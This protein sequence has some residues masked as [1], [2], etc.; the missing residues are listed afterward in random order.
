MKSFIKNN[1]G[2]IAIILVILLFFLCFVL[3]LQWDSNKINGED[4]PEEQYCKEYHK[5]SSLH[6][7]PARC[8]KY[9]DN[10]NCT[11]K[12][13]KMKI[14]LIS[15][16]HFFH[17]KIDGYDDRPEGWVSKLSKQ[18]E[19]NVSKDDL[20]IHLGDVCI[21][22]DSFVNNEMIGKLR[23]RKVL[24][25]GNH[26][27]K[28]YHWYMNNGWDFACRSFVWRNII[29]TH[30]PLQELPQECVLN[31]HGHLH[32][33]K[34]HRDNPLSYFNCCIYASPYPKLVSLEQVKNDY[35]N[36]IF[37]KNKNKK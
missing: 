31:I 17:E 13:Q 27:S 11:S 2:I 28:S 24:V 22:K 1:S 18:W 20:V 8:F 15:D 37:P 23:G 29:F 5:N 34:S 9:Y 33:E 36:N 25:K 14:W 26:D 30:E 3:V 4:M 32:S 16:T 35:F 19:L 21:G 7:M 10:F 12:K 6:N